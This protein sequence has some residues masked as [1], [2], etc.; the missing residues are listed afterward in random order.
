MLVSGDQ[1]FVHK[2]KDMSDIS[3]PEIKYL[4]CLLQRQLG[5]TIKIRQQ[6][7]KCL[8]APG[9]NYGSVMLALELTLEDENNGKK[10]LHIVAKLLP[11]SEMLRQIFYVEITFKK[12]LQVYT[13]IVP[14]LKQIEDE[15]NVENNRASELYCQCYG[16]RLNLSTE[17]DLV[18]DDAV[19]L[20][21]NL[22]LQN[23]E[24]GDRLI[25]FDLETSAFI[26]KNLA[27]YHA[28]PIALK[29]LK[30]DVYRDKIYNTLNTAQPE[31]QNN[32]SV[33]DIV[34]I[35]FKKILMQRPEYQTQIDKLATEAKKSVEQLFYNSVPFEEPFVSVGHADFWVNNMM[36]LRDQSGKPL[37][38]K[39]VD[40]QTAQSQSVV[41]DMLFFIYTSVS[42][43]VLY[44]N[45][46]ELIQIYYASFID[47]LKQFNV[48]L[49]NYSWE[50]FE[51][52]IRKKAY[53]VLSQ[54]IVMYKHILLERGHIADM[55]DF[56]EE[57]MFGFDHVGQESKNR[58][59]QT[60]V[61]FVENGW[62]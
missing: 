8:T 3:V 14:A 5:K 19:I 29:L 34:E 46:D 60:F 49:D 51:K 42:A 56:K 31:F 43:N 57:E 59:V 44:D 41:W 39:I 53:G 1:I 2:F 33:L 50:A 13:R 45:V 15:Y 25:G 26:L 20:L 21:E 28:V 40:F 18:D 12:E 24:T 61:S 58:M 10:P 62:M 22:K 17:D 38:L 37:R 23:Y 4:E 16:G 54:I 47:C 11:P 35:S 52:E 6:Q 27:R 55:G 48:N 32:V 36:L 30:P 7:S 9:E